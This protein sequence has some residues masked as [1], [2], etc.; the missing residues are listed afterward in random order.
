[1]LPISFNDC[2]E[3]RSATASAVDWCDRDNGHQFHGNGFGIRCGPRGNLESE[4]QIHRTGM[5]SLAKTTDQLPVVAA[6]RHRDNVE[7]QALGRI[8]RRDELDFAEKAGF[9][10][11]A[12]LVVTSGFD[13]FQSA[14]VAAA[15]G[16]RFKLI[17]CLDD[18]NGRISCSGA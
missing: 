5:S 1:M 15:A 4:R 2:F 14:V 9:G 16:L 3:D 12:G 7:I 17:G 6:A 11:I 18:R 8:A 10:A 13:H